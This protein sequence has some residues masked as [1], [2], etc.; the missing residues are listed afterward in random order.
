MVIWMYLCGYAQLSNEYWISN[1]NEI[2]RT[3][4]DRQSQSLW[5]ILGWQDHDP[6]FFET[7]VGQIITLTGKD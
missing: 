1:I 7:D 3:D 2:Q 4:G 6:Y 5:L